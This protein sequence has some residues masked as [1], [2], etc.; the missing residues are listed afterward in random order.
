MVEVP[1]SV[2]I[3]HCKFLQLPEEF[4]SWFKEMLRYYCERGGASWSL[5]CPDGHRHISICI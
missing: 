5:S 3:S 2:K 4:H 1:I